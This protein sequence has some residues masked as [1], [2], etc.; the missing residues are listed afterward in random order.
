MV[1]LLRCALCRRRQRE[2]D[3]LVVARWRRLIAR[4]RRLRRLQSYWAFLG[5]YLQYYPRALRL[6]L[7]QVWLPPSGIPPRR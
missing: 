4:L 1:R 5:Q 2:P 3:L 6:R 7:R